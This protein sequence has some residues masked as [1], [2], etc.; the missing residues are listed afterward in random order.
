VREGTPPSEGLLNLSKERS[1]TLVE[2]FAGFVAGLR[3]DDLPDAVLERVRL[4]TLDL[5]G[6]CLL[7]ARMPFGDMLHATVEQSSGTAESS[8]IGR[9]APRL[10]APSAALF[11]GGLAHGNEFDDTYPPGRWHASAA[12][13]PALLAVAEALDVDGRAFLVAAAGAM[14]VGCRLTRAAPALLQ[15]GFHST[16]TAGVL[17]SALGVARLMALAPERVANAMAIAGSFVSG[18]VEFLDDPEAWPKRIQ[19]GYAAQGAIIAA[20]AAATGFKGPRSMLEGR[21]GYFRS[22]AGEGN[23]TLDEITADLGTDWQLL[24][25][26]PKRYPCDHIAQGYLDCALALSRA[27]PLAPDEIE[28]VEVIVHP[29]ARAVMFEPRDLR[30]APPNGWSARWSMPF[31]MAIALL[32]ATLGIDSY[33]DARAVD[34][35]TRAVMRKVVP[36]EDASLPFPGQYPAWV[37]VHTAGRGVR[38][39]KQ[40]WVA[41]SPQNPV[42]A[43][44]YEAK[45]VD[46]ARRTLGPDRVRDLV[47]MLRALPHLRSMRLLASSYA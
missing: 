30:Y 6:V 42:H 33:T 36:V 16:A 10:P 14:E 45:F 19:A 2:S 26:C 23:Y 7:G 47:T 3:Y 43:A 18:T 1:T 12:T 17:C 20:R 34:S 24:N 13:L 31:N 5:I 28:R 41:G 22:Y 9:A 15:R 8:L 46:N 35:A 27:A 29:L 37:R 44:E 21:Y 40:L 4:H 39:R 38:E 11:M 25:V 32:D